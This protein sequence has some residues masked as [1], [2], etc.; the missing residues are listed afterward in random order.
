MALALWG[1]VLVQVCSGPFASDD[2]VTDGPFAHYLSDAGVEV[3]TAIH[4]R[5]CWVIVVLIA[6][7]LGALTWYA[8][9]RDPV[10]LSMWNGRSANGLPPIEGHLA[11]RAAMTAI[12]AAA[13]VWAG[14]RWL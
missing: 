9:R 5:I 6:I 2:I 3:A 12:A 14:V 1:A 11:L 10:V 8:W 4:S 13:L 7:H